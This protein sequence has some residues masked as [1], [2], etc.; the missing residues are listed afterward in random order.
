MGEG[1]DE[2]WVGEMRMGWERTE[3]KRWGF[4]FGLGERKE[5]KRT[6]KMLLSKILVLVHFYWVLVSVSAKIKLCEIGKI[7]LQNQLVTEEIIFSLGRFIFFLFPLLTLSPSPPPKTPLFS[8]SPLQKKERK[9]LFS[10]HLLRI[11]PSSQGTANI[12]F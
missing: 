5:R 7:V 1:V 4:S 2:G 9:I 6:L 10:P 12:L 11:L 8:P 3:K